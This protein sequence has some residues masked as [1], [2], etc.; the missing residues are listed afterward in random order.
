MDR[1]ICL[2]PG[3]GYE[4]VCPLFDGAIVRPIA[5]D[6]C[7][8]SIKAEMLSS[9]GVS[10]RST[11]ATDDFDSIHPIDSETSAVFPDTA[12]P[13]PSSAPADYASTSLTLYSGSDTESRFPE[14]T[15]MSLCE[16]M[17]GSARYSSAR[18]PSASQMEAPESYTMYANGSTRGSNLGP[19]NDVVFIFQ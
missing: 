14:S 15:A 13:P 9:F 8:D 12:M 2:L 7:I 4:L 5:D 6:A 11:D 1:L 18:V 16:S 3:C 19:G 10:I 17:A